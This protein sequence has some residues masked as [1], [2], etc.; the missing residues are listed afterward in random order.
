MRWRGD[1]FAKYEE[2]ESIG[3]NKYSEEGKSRVMPSA[4]QISEHIYRTS[5]ARQVSRKQQGLGIHLYFRLKT[6]CLFPRLQSHGD[7]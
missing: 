1:E 5:V 7:P 4:A 2:R 6:I 3:L